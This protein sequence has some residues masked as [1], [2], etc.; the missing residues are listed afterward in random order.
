ML[1]FVFLAF[2]T[3]S[4]CLPFLLSA[5]VDA[6][7]Y[8]VK[9]EEYKKV[10]NYRAAIAE[11]DKAHKAA[12]DNSDFLVEK[13]KCYILLKDFDNAA[14]ALEKAVAVKN[15]EVELMISLAKIY[16]QLGNMNKTIEYLQKAFTVEKNNANKKKYKEQI[17]KILQAKKLCVEADR[18]FADYLEK[19]P[20]DEHFWFLAAQNANT[21]GLFTKAISYASYPLPQ[22]K[23]PVAA[24]KYHYEIALASYRSEN[25]SKL[26]EHT[27][28]AA[29]GAFKPMVFRFTAEYQCAV[30]QVFL[31][32]SDFESAKKHLL[33]AQKINEKSPKI[34]ETLSM[35][36]ELQTNKSALIE[37]LQKAVAAENSAHRKMEHFVK[38]SQ[39]CLE[40]KRFTEALSAADDAVKIAPL[41]F[42]AYFLKAWALKH[43]GK[44]QEA[45]LQLK[46]IINLPELSPEQSSLYALAAALIHA[47]NGEKDAAETCLSKVHAAPFKFA[48]N[49]LSDKIRA[50][51]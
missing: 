39:L 24:A 14:V 31:K 12:P 30:A 45:L 9:A 32:L 22:Q 37:T 3:F 21:A 6:V 34:A 2:F 28:K 20:E 51:Q 38:I 13:S 17:I 40:N 36:A 49:E 5:Q 42:H 33:K 29:H 26:K 1:R 23:D 44:E 27:D 43:L 7:T 4:S 19:F 35:I 10:K 15:N 8:A 41:N 11:Y 46:Q 50:K 18:H 47:D 48:A 25:F 16:G